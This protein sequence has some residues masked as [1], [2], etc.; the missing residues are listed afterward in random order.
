M[1]LSVDDN[2]VLCS[3]ANLLKTCRMVHYRVQFGRMSLMNRYLNDEN[4]FERKN[5]AWVQIF[6]DNGNKAH[7][8][9]L[10]GNNF[11]FDSLGNRSDFLINSLLISFWVLTTDNKSLK[12]LS[13]LDTDKNVSSVT[14]EKRSNSLGNDI[15][16]DFMK[17]GHVV[18]L[19]LYWSTFRA[20]PLAFNEITSAAESFRRCDLMR[21]RFSWD[22]VVFQ[23]QDGQWLLRFFL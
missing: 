11:W 6:M 13:L 16:Q 8:K 4:I 9:K 7:L 10:T 3:N 12:L 19:V 17:V 18:V 2:F 21:N 5:L 22:E 14:V 23:G 15:L 1:H 20:Q